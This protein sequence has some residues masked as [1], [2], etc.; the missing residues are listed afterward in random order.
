MAI[1][2]STLPLLL[3]AALLSACGGSSG[4]DSSSS[5]TSQKPDQQQPTSPGDKPQPNPEPPAPSNDDDNDGVLNEQDIDD[6]NDGLIEISSIAMFNNIRHDLTGSSYHD[7]SQAITIGCPNTETI[8]GCNGY[9]LTQTLNFSQSEFAKGKGDN[10]GWPAIGN[11]KTPFKAQFNGN[12]FT[13]KNFYINQNL[14]YSGLFGALQDASVVNLNIEGELVDG[15]DTKFI[16]MLAGFIRSPDK[17]SHSAGIIRNVHVSGQITANSSRATGALI[18][19]QSSGYYFIEYCS[20]LPCEDKIFNIPAATIMAVSAEVNITTRSGRVGGLIGIKSGGALISS[21]AKGN[22]E[23]EYATLGGLVGELKSGPQQH[24]NR[25]ISSFAANSLTT[26]RGSVAGGLVGN[27][28]LGSE[29]ISSYSINTKVFSNKEAAGFVGQWASSS[30]FASQK[31]KVLNSYSRS[32]NIN[33]GSFVHGFSAGLFN[34]RGLPPVVENSYWDRNKTGDGVVFSQP[35]NILV[36]RSSHGAGYSSAQLTGAEAVN[37]EK[38]G[39]LPGSL[40]KNNLTFDAPYHHWLPTD[41]TPTTNDEKLR[42]YC[43]DNGDGVIQDNENTAIWNMGNNQQYP[44]INC[45]AAEH[46]SRD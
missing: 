40:F 6:D 22:I 41:W 23:S 1:K 12:N 15:G 26:T 19:E 42:V 35:N 25:I 30:G 2:H 46:Q 17:N 16:G 45:I 4:G 28:Y 29:I 3:S 21:F 9:E 32:Q 33:G 18:G 11:Y 20:P 31:P 24:K 39:Y 5:P 34:E 8:K 44:I 27:Q 36:L 7:G 14:E 10:L 38:P 37:N 13:L 43:D